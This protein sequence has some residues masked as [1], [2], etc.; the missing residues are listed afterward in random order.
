[1]LQSAKSPQAS[2]R[3]VCLL[4]QLAKLYIIQPG[5]RKLADHDYAHAL[6]P[7]LWRMNCQLLGYDGRIRTYHLSTAAAAAPAAGK[8]EDCCCQPHLL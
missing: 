5:R 3:C 8:L 6:L 7:M 1:M 4:D 2:M